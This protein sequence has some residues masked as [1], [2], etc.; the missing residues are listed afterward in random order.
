[1][2]ALLDDRLQDSDL[3]DELIFTSCS[4]DPLPGK[5]VSVTRVQ[6]AKK[7]RHAGQDSVRSLGA[8]VMM[9]LYSPERKAALGSVSNNLSLLL[10]TSS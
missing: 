7:M 5:T 4:N 9:K 1:M 10:Y 2:K 6:S 3:H 8:N